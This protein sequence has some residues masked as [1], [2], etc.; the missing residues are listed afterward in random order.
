MINI[1][2]VPIPVSNISKILGLEFNSPR[3]QSHRNLNLIANRVEIIKILSSHIISNCSPALSMLTI[4]N[5]LII[6]NKY[7]Y[8]NVGLE[9][10]FNEATNVNLVFT[11]G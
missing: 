2:E 1:V 5:I 9:K 11:Y 4:T 8:K 7:I 6:K 10:V 3:I